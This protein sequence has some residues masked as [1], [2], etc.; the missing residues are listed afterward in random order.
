VSLK[1]TAGA[2]GVLS[3][4]AYFPVVGTESW[5]PVLA[6][7]LKAEAPPPGRFSPYGE[8]ADCSVPN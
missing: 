5:L 4:P 7:D 8:V 2:S 3:P 1:I 6:E